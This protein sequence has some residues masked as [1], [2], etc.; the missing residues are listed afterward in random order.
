MPTPMT[1]AAAWRCLERFVD[2][3]SGS[4]YDNA[5]GRV[6]V[7][8]A[9]QVR[10][11]LPN[12]CGW[13]SGIEDTALNLGLLVPAAI[14]M[15]ER[16]GAREWHDA[17]MRMS[18]LMLRLA[19]VSCVP[20]FIARGV[21]T[22]GVTHYR[23]SSVDQYTMAFRALDAIS[24]WDAAGSERR[25][26]SRQVIADVMAL[27]R[28]HD[29]NI[30]TSDGEAAWVSE[31]S[32]LWSD[33]GTRLLQLALTD[34][35]VN[36]SD[37]TLATYRELRDAHGGRRARGLFIDPGSLSV[38]YA[39]LQTQV[40]VAMLRDLEP[41]A[42]H[43]MVWRLMADD[44]AERAVGQLQR[45]DIDLLCRRHGNL[46]VLP[47]P[48]RALDVMTNADTA[49]RRDLAVVAD[50]T[51][52]YWAAN[53]RLH[54]EEETIRQPLELVMCFALANTDHLVNHTG[55]EVLPMVTDVASR[56]LA[57]VAP[58][59]VQSCHSATMLVA[60]AEWLERPTIGLPAVSMR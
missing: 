59:A 7:P 60:V 50:W 2:P 14:A 13:G 57:S 19:T 25:R 51:G 31:T 26:R 37:V 27:L 34:A 29:W 43:R 15:A 10:D 3:G 18:D 11:D 44:V 41:D 54:T 32:E 9:D 56:I 40:S 16:S 58:E 24:G 46:P 45:L 47:G 39:L 55:T 48:T 23:N 36:P 28:T 5:L 21:L 52:R 35:A 12:Q 22:D 17:A 8:S 38:P 20:G 33:R 49:G 30:P 53:P 1:A 42:S 6:G 4:L